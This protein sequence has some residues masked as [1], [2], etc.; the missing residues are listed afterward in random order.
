[1]I[2]RGIGRLMPTFRC[3]QTRQVG[4]CRHD[5]IER[6]SAPSGVRARSPAEFAAP[7][8]SASTST[9]GQRS[10]LHTNEVSPR[11][12]VVPHCDSGV[13]EL[14]PIGSS[15]AHVVPMHRR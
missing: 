11:L 12:L 9:S 2:S 15:R 5:V 3:L 6:P 14:P 10:L 1:M 7:S 13:L 4:R 8:R